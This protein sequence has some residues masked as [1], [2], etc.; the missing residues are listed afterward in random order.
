MRTIRQDRFKEPQM[1]EIAKELTTCPFEKLHPS[2]LNRD[3][4]FFMK[5]AYNLAID[6]WNADEVP[7]GTVIVH[8]EEV[9]AS[10]R[11]ETRIANDPTAHAEIIAITKAASAI[12][13]WRL[14][15]CRLYVTKEPCPMC[16]GAVIMS[17]IGEVH[18]A[19]PDSK[20]GCLGGAT[21]L[22]ALPF[23]NHKAKVSSGLLSQ[24]SLNLLQ[25]YFQ[26][27]RQ[28]PKKKPNG[29]K[30]IEDNPH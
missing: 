3:D 29:Q 19:V 5:L 16:S 8:G 15:E 18:Y 30:V 10:A 14:N 9:I 21:D 22:N 17:R 7:V 26:V 1:L 23:S 20:M 25:A 12:G 11:N 6:A 27:K 4:E 13:D 28:N 24:Q 2:Q